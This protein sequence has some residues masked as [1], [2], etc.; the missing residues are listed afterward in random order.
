VGDW[1]FLNMPVGWQP[2]YRPTER[3]PPADSTPIAETPRT[4]V[5]PVDAVERAGPRNPF[6]GLGQAPIQPRGELT[7]L[8]PAVKLAPRPPRPEVRPDPKPR[9]KPLPRPLP[10]PP[11]R[12]VARAMAPAKPVASPISREATLI[13]RPP[14]SEAVTQI[15]PRPRPIV[16]QTAGLRAIN[17]EITEPELRTLRTAIHPIAEHVYLNPGR[18]AAHLGVGLVVAGAAAVVMRR[19]GGDTDE[20]LEGIA[21]KAIQPAIDARIAALGPERAALEAQ[22]AP[23]YVNVKLERTLTCTKDFDGGETI[24]TY[25]PSYRVLG[26]TLSTEPA[27]QPSSA[28]HTEFHLWGWDSAEEVIESE[29]LH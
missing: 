2:T 6:E 10:K 26:V 22:L 18:V 11:E 9:P 3:I 12:A 16:T 4:L 7:P 5:G 19:L 27:A 14:S 13:L 20:L 24:E 23:I 15:A 17:S 29:Q 21:R 28:P 1:D 8:R 25:V